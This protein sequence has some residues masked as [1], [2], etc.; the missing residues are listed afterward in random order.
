MVTGGVAISALMTEVRLVIQ[1]HE[2]VRDALKLAA[3][4]HR[5]EMSELASAILAEALAAEIAELKEPTE[6]P[7]GRK[8]DKK[9]RPE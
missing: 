6:R 3:A 1:T 9:P 4:R 2:V 5:M 8:P 7:K